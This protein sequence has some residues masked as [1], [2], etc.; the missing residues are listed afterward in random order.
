MSKYRSVSNCGSAI[1]EAI[2]ASM[3]KALAEKLMEVANL[4]GYHYV[5]SG[6]V[7]TKIYWYTNGIFN[8][9]ESLFF[10]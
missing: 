9:R 1:G 10:N 3:E 8:R 4:Y 6:V 2:G 5:T 7:E